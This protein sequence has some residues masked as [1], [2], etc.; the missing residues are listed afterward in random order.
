M[1]EVNLIEDE[2]VFDDGE[3]Q[4]DFVLVYVKNFNISKEREDYAIKQRQNFIRVLIEEHKIQIKQV[5]HFIFE[6]ITQ[7]ELI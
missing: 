4:I 2:V 6:R 5:G 1:M 3:T 7:H